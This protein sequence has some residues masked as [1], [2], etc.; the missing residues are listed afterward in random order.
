MLENHPTHEGGIGYYFRE[1]GLTD[2]FGL[3]NFCKAVKNFRFEADVDDETNATFNRCDNSAPRNVYLPSAFHEWDY[4]N[5]VC[6][7]GS[8]SK[9]YGTTNDH[10]T[11]LTHCKIFRVPVQ[12]EKGFIVYLEYFNPENEDYSMQNSEC[13]G[14]TFQEVF[15]GILEWAWVHENMGNNEQVAIAA[16]EFINELNIPEDILD[17]LWASVPDQKVARY[18][19]GHTDARM[20]APIEGIPDM[21][22]E[23]NEWVEE[24]IL[25]RP[26]IWPYGPK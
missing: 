2:S 11:C 26:T 1:I 12:T 23:F 22:N 14:R 16:S 7:C 4:E 21:T 6:S 15:R 25:H 5:E 10:Y 24:L 19:R 3:F 18:L 8:T 17:W 9:P 13:N 20:R